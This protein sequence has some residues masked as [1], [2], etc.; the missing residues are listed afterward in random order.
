VWGVPGALPNAIRFFFGFLALSQLV[1]PHPYGSD[2]LVVWQITGIAALLWILVFNILLPFIREAS[3]PLPSGKRSFRHALWNSYPGNV[4]IGTS[5]FIF[6]AVTDMTN[7]LLLHYPASFSR[8]GLCAF[9]LTMALM[10]ARLYGKMSRELAEKSALLENAGNPAGAR[11]AV[12]RARG[13]TEREKEVARLV[14]EGMDN[15]TIASQLFVSAAAVSFHLTNI[16]RKFGIGGKNRE[17]AAFVAKV[18]G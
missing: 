18:L 16:Y 11:E 1:F 13:L 6:S 14:V 2:A 10:L 5:L 17:R 15:E 9:V 8:Y 3:R 4:L 7:S 12:F